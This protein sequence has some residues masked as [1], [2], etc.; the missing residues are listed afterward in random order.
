M[1]FDIFSFMESKHTNTHGPDACTFMSLSYYVDIK[2]CIVLGHAV[3]IVITACP[4]TTNVILFSSF[5]LVGATRAAVD[6]GFVPN[7]LQVK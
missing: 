3:S 2:L 1:P 5:C 4:L 6:A 7:D